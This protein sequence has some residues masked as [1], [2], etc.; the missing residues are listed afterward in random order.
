MAL[1]DRGRLRFRPGSRAQL[2]WLLVVWG[3]VP[4]VLA[5]TA[6]AT[7]LTGICVFVCAPAGDGNHCEPSHQPLS[8]AWHTALDDVAAPIALTTSLPPASYRLPLLNRSGSLTYPLRRG[9]HVFTAMWQPSE[10]K[11]PL[12]FGVNF[13]FNGD[14][15][16]P[17]IAAIVPTWTGLGFTY[18]HAN[19]SSTTYS[20][21][22]REV[23]NP[24]TLEYHDGWNVVTVTVLMAGHSNWFAPWDRVG[25]NTFG[26]DGK[27]DAIAIIELSVSRSAG[28]PAAAGTPGQTAEPAV[29]SPREA[30]LRP[31]ETA[32]SATPPPPSVASP[33]AG[34][35]APTPPT[36]ATRTPTV[37]R[38]PSAS[39]S[40]H[41]R[42]GG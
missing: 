3:L 5:S 41:P 16:V 27:R 24:A 34:T 13:F 7:A 10:G 12:R 6:H 32:P 42:S 35:P 19:L 8:I 36:R 21:Y 25:T 14:P 30:I 2:Q 23:E 39:R 20:L 11:L 38:T 18:F 33:T 37:P 40:R 17:G 4:V 29:S 9:K 28:A 26:R 1:G 22:M 15:L 31:D